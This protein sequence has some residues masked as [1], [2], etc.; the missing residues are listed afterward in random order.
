MGHR[1][2]IAAVAAA[3]ELVLEEYPRGGIGLR[4]SGVT[5]IETVYPD[6]PAERAGLRSGDEVI[7]VDGV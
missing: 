2:V 7:A 6:T 3:G 1:R 5:T 4:M